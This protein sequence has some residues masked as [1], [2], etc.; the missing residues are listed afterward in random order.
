[1]TLGKFTDKIISQYVES[2]PDVHEVLDSEEIDHIR[3]RNQSGILKNRF[4]IPQH[5]HRRKTYRIQLILGENFDLVSFVD[6]ITE[7]ITGNYEINIDLGYFAFK[8]IEE[9]SLRFIFPAKCTSFIKAI[10]IDSESREQMINQVKTASS[11][12]LLHAYLAHQENTN[13]AESG[14]VPRSTVMLETFIT[15]F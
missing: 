13:F 1:M 4:F 14:F 9:N 10:V 11:N 6:E 2:A 3:K 15:T 8:P 5:K 7:H 12:L